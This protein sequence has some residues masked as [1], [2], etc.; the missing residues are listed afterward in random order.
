MTNSQDEAGLG[1]LHNFATF[2]VSPQNLPFFPSL[3]SEKDIHIAAPQYQKEEVKQ[4]KKE[5]ES[6]KIYL[7]NS[8]SHTQQIKFSLKT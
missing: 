6:K 5:K 8:S 1:Q 4:E 2:N 7:I 3:Q